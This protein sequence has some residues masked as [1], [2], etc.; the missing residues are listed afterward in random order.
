MHMKSFIPER[1][2]P[3]LENQETTENLFDYIIVGSGPAGAI[4]AKKLSEEN[5][6]KILLIEAGEIVESNHPIVW[7]P[8][9]WG[10]IS[11]QESLEW[12]Y[13]STPQTKLNNRVINISQAKGTGGCSLHNA[14]VY[15]RG[16]K[17]GFDQWEKLGC[18]G[19]NYQNMKSNFQEVETEFNIKTGEKN[20]FTKDLIF[21]CE[22]IGIPFIADYNQDNEFGVSQL[23]FFIDENN[24]RQTVYKKYFLENK[25]ENLTI[26]PNT[27]VNKV[28]FDKDKNAIGVECF[29]NNEKHVFRA[30]NEIILSGGAISTPAILM[31][32]GIGNEKFLS[33]LGINVIYNSPNV[34]KNLQDDIFVPVAYKST[35]EM[36]EQENGLMNLVVF[37][38]STENENLANTE[39]ETDIQFSFSSGK[40]ARL[41]E[42]PPENRNAFFMYPNVQLLKS[43]GYVSIIS[44]NPYDLPMVNPQYLTDEEDMSKCIRA[45]KIARKIASTRA[46][47]EWRGLELLPGSDVSSDEEISQY[48]RKNANTCFHYSG[49][50]KMGNS[51]DSVVDPKLIVRGVSKL[52]VIDS[53]IIP[54]TVSGNTAAATMAIGVQGAKFVKES[55]LRNINQNNYFCLFFRDKESHI[56]K[57]I[58]SYLSLSDMVNL[59]YTSHDIHQF[60]RTYLYLNKTNTKPNN[61]KSI[62]PP[63]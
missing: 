36:P 54:R 59:T 24:K 14:M 10:L 8:V 61:T 25:P 6:L 15:V 30:K 41:V 43:R 2:H 53:S 4:V 32:S 57:T 52:R 1:N 40:M 31:R 39:N 17:L 37:N 49:T 62:Q 22:E 63:P 26:S 47:N 48:I 55:R 60:F 58:A 18:E 38:H 3:I 7:D 27:I 50:C 9:K 51:N 42:L 28:L 12:G 44:S 23:R 34:G 46:L 5:N 13:K 33:D 19:W 20:E 35:K 56:A 45:V 11:K 21:A 29:K 16:G